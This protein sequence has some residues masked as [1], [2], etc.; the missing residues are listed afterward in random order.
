M[1]NLKETDIGLPPITGGTLNLVSGYLFEWCYSWNGGEVFPDGAELTL[2][3]AGKPYPFKMNDRRDA[4]LLTL[5]HDEY[6]DM[7]D[8]APFALGFKADGMKEPAGILIGKV[9]R[10]GGK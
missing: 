3:V 2:T 1:A 6:K 4:C 8:R 5:T 9:K 7:T 10:W